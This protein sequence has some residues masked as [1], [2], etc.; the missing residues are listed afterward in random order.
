MAVCVICGKGLSTF[1]IN[2]FRLKG[3]QFVRFDCARKAGHDPM[4]WMGNM[5]TTPDQLMREI[6]ENERK[7]EKARNESSSRQ[8]ATDPAEEIMKYKRLM[9]AGAI[10]Q[11]EFEAKKKKLLDLDD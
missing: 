2:R 3:G 11:E 8:S 9:D 1:G 6:K 10:T 7:M 4:L 5:S